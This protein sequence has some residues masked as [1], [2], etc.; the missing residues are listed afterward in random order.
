MVEL[1]RSLVPEPGGRSPL[2]KSV[3]PSQTAKYAES[4]A[5]QPLEVLAGS[6]IEKRSTGQ[7]MKDR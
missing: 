2:W 1:E 5:E 6:S 3:R 7:P 4:L